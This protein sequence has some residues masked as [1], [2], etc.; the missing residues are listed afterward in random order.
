MHASQ[1]PAHLQSCLK[2]VVPK[3]PPVALPMTSDVGL[4]QK[5]LSPLGEL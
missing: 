2:A 5:V 1:L 3:A 4:A